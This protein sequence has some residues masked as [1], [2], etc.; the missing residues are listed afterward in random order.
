LPAAQLLHR[1][2]RGNG[3]AVGA[4][5][6]TFPVDAHRGG[7]H[8]ALDRTLAQCLEQ[9][10]GSALVDVDVGGD[11]IHAL[12]D[13]DGRREMND[14]VDA[15]QRR[16]DGIAVA[17]VADDELGICAQIGRTPRVGTVHL[18]G[19]IVENANVVAGCEQN[20]GNVGSDKARA[21]GD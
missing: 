20:F 4:A 14:A 17:H 18:R 7:D 16:P 2:R 8:E 21:S 12:A 6:K 19:Q 11:V 13:A 3:I 10:R 1:A 9:H 15:A 5:R